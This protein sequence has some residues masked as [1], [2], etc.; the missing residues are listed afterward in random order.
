MRGAWRVLLLDRA[1]TSAIFYKSGRWDFIVP[2]RASADPCRPQT[3]L[4]NLNCNSRGGAAVSILG[5][6]G[7]PIKFVG[8]S[9]RAQDL[10]AM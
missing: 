6:S 3:I 4:T 7:K 9:K 2:P 10:E 8:I 1:V 5:M